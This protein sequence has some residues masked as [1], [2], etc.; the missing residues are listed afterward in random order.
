MPHT[1]THN[2]ARSRFETTVEGQLCVADYRL[3]NGVMTMTHTGVPPALEGRGIAGEMVAA[4]FEF[5]R[6]NGLKVDPQC[7]YVR[8]YVQRHPETKSLQ[9]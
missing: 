2:T 4:A 1:I 3:Q 6:T 9:V 7:A 8:R 5:A